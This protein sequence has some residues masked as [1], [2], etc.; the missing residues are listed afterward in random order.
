MGYATVDTASLKMNIGA[1]NFQSVGA[2]ALDLQDIKLD[3]DDANGGSWIQ[4]FDPASEG[5]WQPL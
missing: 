4:W 1:A 5:E 3:G 2:E